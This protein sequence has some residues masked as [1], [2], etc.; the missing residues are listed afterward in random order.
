MLEGKQL[1]EIR[2]D[3]RDKGTA[4]L[5]FMQEPP[6]AGR[7][8]VFVGDDLTDED[9][10]AAV[11]S[12]RRMV[13]Q[14]RDRTHPRPVSARE[15]RCRQGLVD[16]RNFR[17]PRRSGLSMRNLDLALI[18]NGRI[19]ALLDATGT[20]VWCCFPRFDGDPKFYALLNDGTDR[21][22]EGL[23]AVDLINF[24]RSEQSYETNTAVLTTRLHDNSGGIVELTDCVPRFAA[25]WATLSAHDDRPFVCAALPATLRWSCVCVPVTPTAVLDHSARWEATTYAL[26]A[27]TSRC[28]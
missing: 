11:A 5:D 25:T 10:F 17:R 6:F 21:T 4:I 14:G 19:G 27:R 12:L 8:P 7:M 9:G 24:V 26:S 20:I 2:P 1:V 16:G 15:F 3:G 13:H 28:D 23:W 18:G 22:T